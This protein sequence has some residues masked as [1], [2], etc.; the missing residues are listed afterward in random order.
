MK[1]AVS[2]ILIALL[3]LSLWPRRDV[4]P[5]KPEPVGQLVE[6]D[7]L[8]VLVVYENDDRLQYPAGQLAAFMS[9]SVRKWVQDHDAEFRA[10]D[11]D[12][13]LLEKE[14]KW[15]TAMQAAKEPY[16]WL[17]IEGQNGGYQ[18]PIPKSPDEM[19]AL[20]EKCK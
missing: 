3:A 10:F 5:P 8:Q 14:Q 19:V 7:G 6:G 2:A 16:P 17:L 18:G 20:M 15:S 11:D 13:P 4:A 1:H 12:T 9:T